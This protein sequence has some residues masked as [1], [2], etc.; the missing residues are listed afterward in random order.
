[1]KKILFMIIVMFLFLFSV[2]TNTFGGDDLKLEKLNFDG[3]ERSY[4]IYLPEEYDGVEQML[5][6][7]VFHGYTSNAM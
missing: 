1:M 2:G 5:L 6:V 4:W 3:V 7:F